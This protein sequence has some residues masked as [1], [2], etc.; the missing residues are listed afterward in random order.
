MLFSIQ[1]QLKHNEFYIE[2]MYSINSK[3]LLLFLPYDT[4]KK[5][6]VLLSPRLKCVWNI[7]GKITVKKGE[8]TVNLSEVEKW[9]I[10]PV[11]VPKKVGFIV[12]YNSHISL[13]AVSTDFDCLRQPL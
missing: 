10:L 11:G 6:S 1:N 2:R 9:A 4:S 12:D 7:E 5:V 3:L 8:N 13:P